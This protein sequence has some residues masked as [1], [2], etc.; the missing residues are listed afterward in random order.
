MECENRFCIYH[1]GEKCSL[2]EV[3]TDMSGRRLCCIYVNID[4]EYLAARR[5]EVLDRYDEDYKSWSE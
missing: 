2:D 1:Q 3:N 5:K 4:E